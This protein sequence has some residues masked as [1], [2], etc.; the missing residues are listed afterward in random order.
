M[1]TYDI[2]GETLTAPEIIERVGLPKSTVA[3]RLRRGIRTWV[4]LRA[5]P[6]TPSEV[7][8]QGAKRSLWRWQS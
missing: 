2:E 5:R 4:Q 1:K 3:P 7:A 6:L 8:R